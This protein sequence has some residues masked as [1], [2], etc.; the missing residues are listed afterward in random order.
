MQEKTRAEEKEREK[1][2]RRKEECKKCAK[3]RGRPP[4]DQT[5]KDLSLSLS[6]LERE[7]ERKREK[8]ERE[9]CKV[10]KRKSGFWIQRLLNSISFGLR[11]SLDSASH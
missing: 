1:K 2:V 11:F 9:N 4:K 8:E 3:V 5:T 7:E 6:R 10:I